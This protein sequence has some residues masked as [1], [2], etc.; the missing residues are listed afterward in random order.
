[1]PLEWLKLGLVFISLSY[2]PLGAGFKQLLLVYLLTSTLYL[3]YLL[4]QHIT[5]KMQ[6]S[7]S[8]L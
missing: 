1:M 3:L 7:Q 5:I 2:L 4:V 8:G 6:S